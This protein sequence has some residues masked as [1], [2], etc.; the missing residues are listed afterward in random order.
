MFKTVDTL[1]LKDVAFELMFEEYFEFQPSTYF[2][3]DLELKRHSF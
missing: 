3:K 1:L 2:S